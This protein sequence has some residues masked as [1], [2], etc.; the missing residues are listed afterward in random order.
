[1]V[2]F[3]RKKVEFTP[4]CEPQRYIKSTKFVIQIL[5]S[6]ILPVTIRLVTSF[7]SVRAHS[8]IGSHYRESAWTTSAGI[9]LADITGQSPFL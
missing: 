5:P 4:Y 2:Y 8:G 1:M 6:D 3:R 9:N 7:S